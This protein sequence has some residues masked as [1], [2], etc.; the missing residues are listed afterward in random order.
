MLLKNTNGSIEAYDGKA[1]IDLLF[2]LPLF[3]VPVLAG[4]TVLPVIERKKTQSPPRN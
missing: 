4:T 2:M 3:I 1:M